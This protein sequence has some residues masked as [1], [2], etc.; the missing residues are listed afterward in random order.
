MASSISLVTTR[1]SL[2]P[3]PSLR[4]F[5]FLVRL[6]PFFPRFPRF[7]LR[8]RLRF[9]LHFFLGFLRCRFFGLSQRSSLSS[10]GVL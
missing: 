8:F 1:F 2:L 3:E 4:E 10:S 9:F 5:S 6:L 7:F